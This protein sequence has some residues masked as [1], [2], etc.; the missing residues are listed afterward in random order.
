MRSIV[1]FARAP[2]KN[3]GKT[4]LRPALG[5]ARARL[6]HE[7]FL[8]DQSEFLRALAGAE[9]R[10]E[11]CVDGDRGAAERCAGGLPVTDQGPGDLGERLERALR[12]VAADGA[13]ASAV[14]GADAPTLPAG[15]LEALFRS[16]EAGADAALIPAKDGGY[17]ALGVRGAPPVVLFSGIPWG[18]E[19]V[20]EATRRAA[21]RGGIRLDVGETW[22]DVD[23][24]ADLLLLARSC[25]D[26]PE[27]APRTG[28]LL[29]KWGIDAPTRGMV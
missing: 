11:L 22:F 16:L 10:A 8:E 25:A 19:R 18:T 7:A 15:H 1:L 12:R 3:S 28:A 20:F 21:E 4:R 5:P 26:D 29:K 2:G 27:R 9:V 14:L 24:P 13:S 6:L 17:V 23:L